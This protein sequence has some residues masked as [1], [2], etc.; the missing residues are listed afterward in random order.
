M[1]LVIML[2]VFMPMILIVALTSALNGSIYVTML[3]SLIIGIAV[4]SSACALEQGWPGRPS[5]PQSR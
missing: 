2:I 3:A 5:A 1:S 4:A